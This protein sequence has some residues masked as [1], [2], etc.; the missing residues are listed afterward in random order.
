[1][2]YTAV[3]SHI[4]SGDILA[5][6]HRKVK[7]W[8]D[9]KVMMVRLFTMSEY[10]HV[11]VAWVYNG[12]IFVIESVIPYVRIVPLSNLLP[13]YVIHTN[14]KWKPETEQRAMDLVGL[15]GYSQLEAVKALFSANKDPNKWECA[16]LVQELYKCD[17]IDLNCKAIPSAIVASAQALGSMDYLEP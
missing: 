17:G 7:S 6:S 13:C 2:K 10:V 5:W 8:Y 16:E 15:A 3:R 1:M 11:G 14:T 4:Q 12:R 9:F